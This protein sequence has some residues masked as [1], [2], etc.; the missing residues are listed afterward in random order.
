MR[1]LVA[2]TIG[3]VCL[4][5][6]PNQRSQ[7]DAQADAE[8]AKDADLARDGA[9]MDASPDADPPDVDPPDADPP[10]ADPPDADPP[11]ADPPDAGSDDAATDPA[12]GRIRDVDPGDAD[13]GDAD[14]ADA[15]D[16]AGDPDAGPAPMPSVGPVYPSGPGWN[17]YI[18]ADGATR[19]DATGAPCTAA[20]GGGY[21]AC[22]HSGEIR[23]FEATGV[24]SCAGITAADALQAFDWVC[25]PGTPWVRIGSIGLRET[26]RLSDLLDLSATPPVWRANTV[27]LED[28]GGAT[29][30][31]TLPGVWWSNA[32]VED[33]DGLGINEA[34]AGTI[35][36]VRSNPSARYRLDADRV[37]LVVQP[38]LAMRGAAGVEVVVADNRIHLW[39]EGEIDGTSASRSIQWNNVSFSVI[40]KV[41]VR[42]T[43]A[44]A[45][46]GIEVSASRN[47]LLFD[48]RAEANSQQ[49]MMITNGSNDNTL[50]R[51]RVVGNGYYGLHLFQTTG[52][53][54]TDVIAANNLHGVV[55]GFGQGNVARDLLLSN[56]T[57][58]GLTM[59]QTSDNRASNIVATNNGLYG[60]FF[61]AAHRN[62]L[63]AYTGVNNGLAGTGS[64]IHADAS[65]HNT[66]LGAAV[67][68]SLNGIRLSST[69][70]TTF[71]D[72]ASAH[73]DFGVNMTLA[74]YGR[75]AGRLMVGGNV[76]S[77][78]PGFGT[79]PG[80]DNACGN[81]GR[82]T[83]TLTTN[84]SLAA[85][86]IAEIPGTVAPFASIADFAAVG[87]H[88]GYGRVGTQPFPDGSNR[89]TCRAGLDCQLWDLS[90]ALGD[91]GNAGAPSLLGV[92]APPSAA[93]V[94][95]H[96]TSGATITFL[97][98]AAELA[99]DGAG[100]DD[101]LC[102]SGE[103][104]VVA[105][106]IGAYRGHGPLVPAG[107]IG[108][109][110]PIENVTLLRRQTL[111]F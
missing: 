60:A 37:G 82:S 78:S 72:L 51:I 12:D 109:G 80:L 106:S 89:S 41:V 22:L 54:V 67:A 94:I 96:V 93:D 84:V 71:V 38:G 56:N 48:V 33:N 26:T 40:R 6:C 10:D 111:G 4:G 83:A 62:V 81:Q 87:P 53:D 91:T 65:N 17:D 74:S 16:D 90:L 46:R 31:S 52:V 36:V 104:C 101:E 102:E 21:T 103:T 14:P 100:D 63:I 43:S 42:G 55:I 39:I 29:L 20:I 86:F 3:L 99:H 5:G 59:G 44:G 30:L 49:G 57:E 15:E 19:F 110:G 76:T 61:S 8:L 18:V 98:R 68:N 1:G 23:V 66:I 47:N 24:S 34:V 108:A 11:D 73:S 27:T 50:G 77:C 2:M 107:M 45:A 69:S 28:A 97:I 88:Q 95:D 32:I 105:E 79:S 9:A 13:P 25:M 35:Y 58:A 70:S 7:E 92:L 64:G 75:F 85:S